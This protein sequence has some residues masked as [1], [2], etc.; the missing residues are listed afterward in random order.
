MAFP[1]VAGTPAGSQNANDAASFTPTMPSGITVGEGLLAFV[2]VDGNPTVTI[3]TAVSGLNWTEIAAQANGSTVRGHLYYK[4]AEGSD[5]LKINFSVNEKASVLI[6]RISGGGTPTATANNGTSTNSDPASHSPAGGAQDYLWFAARMGDATAIATAAPAGYANLLSEQGASA[7]ASSVSVADRQLNAASEDPGA[8]TSANEQWV[9]MTVAVPPAAGGATLNADADTVV[10]T[11][12]DAGLTV[13]RRLDAGAGTVAFTGGDSTYS[14]GSTLT[15]LTIDE[16]PLPIYDCDPWGAGTAAVTVTGTHDAPGVVLQYRIHD[17]AGTLLVDWTDFAGGAGPAWSLT[18]N[19]APSLAGNKITVRGKVATAVTDVQANAWWSGRIA[20]PLGQ[21]LSLRPFD[22][23]VTGTLTPTAKRLWVLF[24]DVNG[25]LASGFIEADAAAVL[26]QR[27]AAE[28]INAYGDAPIGLVLLSEVGTGRA[29]TANAE[30]VADRSW[31]D[32]MQAP[33]DYLRARGTD[34]SL[35]IDHWFTSDAGTWSDFIRHWAPFYLRKQIDGIADNPDG[36]GIQNYAGG[37]VQCVPSRTYTPVH[38]L[39]DLTGGG[40]GLFDPARTK[41]MPA[42]GASHS[43]TGGRADGTWY[44]SDEQKG[45]VR[46]ALQ[47]MAETEAAYQP[48]TLRSVGG[49]TGQASFGGHLAEPAGTH[50]ATTIDGEPLAAISIVT[51]A[52]RAYGSLPRSEPR[53]LSI[54]VAADGSHADLTVDL[55]HGNNLS[56]TYA[57]HQAGA[58]AGSFE[59]TNWVTPAVLPETTIPELH[60]VQGVAIRQG[61][62]WTFSGF[63]TSIFDAGTGTAPSRTGKIRVTPTVPFANGDA[64]S[65]GYADGHTILTGG[66]L[67]NGRPHVHWPIETRAHVSG[68]GYGWPVV[69]EAGD[70]VLFTISGVTGEETLAADAGLVAV[71]GGAASLTVGRRIDADAGIVVF[72]G[73]GAALLAGRII[74]AAP[75]VV[76]VTGGAASLIAGRFLMGDASVIAV[77]G[78]G[79]T[80]SSGSGSAALRGSMA[81]GQ[82][83]Q[84]G[85]VMRGRL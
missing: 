35:V 71:T 84:P 76:A 83:R 10:F 23:A 48:I 27:R 59:A 61:G 68:T 4:V 64:V 63:T 45:E 56:T 13:E 74:S 75:G 57:E 62:N 12:G 67:T 47:V 5:A 33:I 28:L 82:F 49:W 38:F 65:F 55:P 2:A 85:Q 53:I 42:F 60:D 34:V 29:E 41:W 79:V 51:A 46:E 8:V 80:L 30:E 77:A 52:L 3:D 24:N 17:A 72:T 6:Y 58:Y 50:V 7:S 36:S 18:L 32:T 39:Y 73:V 25:T 11:G 70:Q 81:S 9:C 16:Q 15:A 40:Q 37:S 14:T 31:V 26:G 69:R 43:G 54:T 1:S 21:S 66:D 22:I 20:V 78:G 44:T 19:R